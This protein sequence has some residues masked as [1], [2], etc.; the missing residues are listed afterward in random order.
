MPLS[1]GRVDPPQDFPFD[2]CEN[3]SRGLCAELLEDDFHELTENLGEVLGIDD[4]LPSQADLPGFLR[5]HAPLSEH[6]A[7]LSP[8]GIVT[9]V[10]SPKQ[11]VDP[12][13]E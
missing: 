10:H 12:E 3:G 7:K 1:V 13:V 2:A 6:L 11:V 4:L 5:S 8:C 9:I